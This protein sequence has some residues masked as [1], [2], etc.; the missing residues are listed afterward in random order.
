MEDKS[1]LNP[2][3][4]SNFIDNINTEYDTTLMDIV[5]FMHARENDFD[6]SIIEDLLNAS[7]VSAAYNHALILAYEKKGFDYLKAMFYAAYEAITT[8]LSR[9]IREIENGPS[10]ADKA[11]MLCK[12][13]LKDIILDDPNKTENIEFTGQ[14]Y[15]YPIKGTL[16]MWLYLVDGI[17]TLYSN[18]TSFKFLE[19]AAVLA[20]LYLEDK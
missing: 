15:N 4:V 6:E 19:S 1:K 16:H 14:K 10:S 7:V 11:S 2:K 8:T 3:V 5:D 17:Y 13:Y 18:C 12:I 20:N 9:F